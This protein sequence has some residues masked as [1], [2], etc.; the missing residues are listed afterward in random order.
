MNLEIS[1]TLVEVLHLE[2]LADR[3][4]ILLLSYR[5]LFKKAIRE[6]SPLAYTVGAYGGE[7]TPVPI[8]NTVVKLTYAH[9]TLREAAREDRS[10]PT[11][12]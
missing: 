5:K 6:F 4:L 3:F 2:A 12:Q 8:P 11:F 1:H 10:V 9:N 7:G